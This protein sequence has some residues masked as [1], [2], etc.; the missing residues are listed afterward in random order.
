MPAPFLLLA[1]WSAAMREPSMPG[2]AL[3]DCER[4]AEHDDA[5]GEPHPMDCGCP[6]C[7]DDSPILD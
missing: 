6:D 7:D 1:A 4:E 3:L 5:E 2:L